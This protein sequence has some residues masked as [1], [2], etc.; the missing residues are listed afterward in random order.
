MRGCA[1]SHG[2]PSLTTEVVTVAVYICVCATMSLRA[3]WHR[4][5]GDLGVPR[6]TGVG[7]SECVCIH[8]GVR[9]CTGV[10]AWVPEQGV[11]L[12]LCT[13]TTPLMVPGTRR[14]A[15]PVCLPRR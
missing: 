10:R 13:A 3:W 2:L 11:L 7:V 14:R 8:L 6:G 5:V 12:R 4:P 9:W 15:V 1:Y